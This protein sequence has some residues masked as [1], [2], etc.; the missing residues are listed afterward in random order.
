MTEILMTSK[1]M[2]VARAFIIGICIMALSLMV[3][4]E[5]PYVPEGSPG[6]F[7]RRLDRVQMSVNSWSRQVDES[8][9]APLDLPNIIFVKSHKV[10]SSSMSNLL[11]LIAVRNNGIPREYLYNVH[12]NYFFARHEMLPLEPGMHIWT[13]HKPLSTLVK[14]SSPLVIRKSFKMTLV[15]KPLDRMLS[16]FYYYD[17]SKNKTNRV[18][19]RD[20]GD[21]TSET[22]HFNGSEIKTQMFEVGPTWNASVEETMEWYDFIGITGRYTETLTALK[23]ILGLRLGDMLYFDQKV[24]GTGNRVERPPVE[25]EDPAVIAHMKSLIE[26]LDEDLYQAANRRLSAVIAQL[27]PQ[28]ISEHRCIVEHLGRARRICANEREVYPVPDGFGCFSQG[29]CRL[30]CLNGYANKNLLWAV[31]PPARIDLRSFQH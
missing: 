15:R 2:V 31:D 24:S 7:H 18:G 5:Y 14:N 27:Q 3:L 23:M 16:A 8:P 30:S 26:P 22:F 9:P 29:V 25:E 4:F 6:E 20:N 11:R 12:A 1:T 13:D 10:G 19:Y 21:F 17:I 28:F